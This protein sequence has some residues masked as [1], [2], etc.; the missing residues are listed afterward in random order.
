LD[1]A[2]QLNKQ[3]TTQRNATQ[4]N[5][6]HLFVCSD[7][8]QPAMGPREIP[9][10][11]VLCLRGVGN[12]KCKADDTF[13]P[14]KDGKPS[15]ASRLLRSFHNRPVLGSGESMR[16]YLQREKE[17]VESLDDENDS[18]KAKVPTLERIPMKRSL[19][20]GKGSG[21]R[22][23]AND[24][25][26]N[27][28]WVATFLPPTIVDE[29]EEDDENED[30]NDNSSG[31]DNIPADPQEQTLVAESGSCA[32]DLLQSYIDSLVEMGRMDD[33]RLGLQFFAEYKTNIELQYRASLPVD[34]SSSSME[35]SLA[36]QQ[37][38]PPSQPEEAALPAQMLDTPIPKKKKRKRS[39]GGALS[40][41]KKKKDAEAK[42]AAE[43]KRQ[44]AVLAAVPKSH[45]S[46]SLHNCEVLTETTSNLLTSRILEHIHALDLTGLQTLTDARLL[47]VLKSAGLQLERLSVK[48]CRRL[49]DESI[50]NVCASCPNLKAIDFGG[51][52]NLRPRTILD[53]LSVK[54]SR[55]G[56]GIF[57][58]QALPHLVELH[59]GGIGPTG[60]W[61]DDLMPEL[62]A[63]RGWKAL[64]IGF[65]PYL[66][67]AGWKEALLSVEHKHKEEQQQEIN[68]NE[69]GGGEDDVSNNNNKTN[70]MCQTLQ[71]LG[72]GFCEQQLVDNAWLG[73]V[74]RHLPNLRALDV[75]GNHHLQTM[76]SWY[77]GR[78]TISNINS[79][80]SNNPRVH[81]KQSL[82]VLARY[83]GISSNSVEETK[84][85]YPLA[86]TPLRV[87]TESEGIGWGILRQEAATPKDQPA[88]HYLKR[89]AVAKKEAA[90]AAATKSNTK[91]NHPITPDVAITTKSKVV[92]IVPLED[93]ADPVGDH[94]KDKE[95]SRIAPVAMETN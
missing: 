67:F 65:S 7:T 50:H 58:S 64:S 36:W 29:E 4:R 44:A 22:F 45:A 30:G 87:V 75:R 23:Q 20:I 85:I 92:T 88:M 12:P 57:T 40:A 2:R 90:A 19:A 5:A 35:S 91:S 66:T 32:L 95:G 48:N 46:L 53:A 24:V 9:A 49:T 69:T 94:A 43:A 62:F 76:T 28:P 13:A 71:S 72:I 63:L 84:R 42:V 26:L 56:R 34:D 16:D 78:A 80:N 10:L 8:T 25:D 41:A 21:R 37:E 11:S 14:T 3:T 82:V 55:R 60:G 74:G 39:G 89:L 33:N 68:I 54:I 6:T 59:A 93:D 38:T 77:D 27:H 83:S 61:T 81:P 31:D 79:S 1:S 15:S 70:N 86:A 52:Y 73:L 17:A 18:I 51:D 47:P